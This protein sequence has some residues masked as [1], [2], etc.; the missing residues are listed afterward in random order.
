MEEAIISSS[1]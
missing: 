1:V